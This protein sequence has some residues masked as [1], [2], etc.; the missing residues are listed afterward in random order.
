MDKETSGV[1]KITGLVHTAACATP[2]GAHPVAGP[3]VH[4]GLGRDP[5]CALQYLIAVILRT[6]HTSPVV[7]GTLENRDDAQ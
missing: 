3:A 4:A 5:R 1:S 7:P 2:Q 6:N